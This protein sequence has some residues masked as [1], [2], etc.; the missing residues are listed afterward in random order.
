LVVLET[1]AYNT[2][3]VTNVEPG[4]QAW[5]QNLIDYRAVRPAA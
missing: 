1:I 4:V 5:E 3:T 2:D